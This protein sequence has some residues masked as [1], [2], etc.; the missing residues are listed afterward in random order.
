MARLLQR[1]EIVSI[2][3]SFMTKNNIGQSEGI[4]PKSLPFLDHDVFGKWIRQSKPLTILIAEAPLWSYSDELLGPYFYFKEYNKNCTMDMT[5]ILLDSL[6]ISGSSKEARLDLFK[7]EGYLLLDAIKCPVDVKHLGAPRMRSLLRESGENILAEELRYLESNEQL[8]CIVTM[9]GSAARALNAGIPCSKL[10][11]REIKKW[12]K[13]FDENESYHRYRAELNDLTSI[14]VL[15]W[16][17]PSR[18]SN[19]QTYF[20]GCRLRNAIEKYLKESE[21]DTGSG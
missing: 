10:P 11:R 15:P 2:Y 16:V 14:P 17:F 8:R 19:P 4:R 18:W 12:I 9:G 6:G 21:L 5:R 20:G 1:M 7:G 13:E 3:E